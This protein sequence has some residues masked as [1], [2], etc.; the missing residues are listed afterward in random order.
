MFE[1][2]LVESTGKLA[3]RS[4]WTL[5]FSLAVQ[6]LIAGVLVLLPLIYM[7]ALPEQHL[8]RVLEAPAPP[9]AAA[10]ASPRVSRSAAP[11]S[12]LDHGVLRPPAEIPRMI[13]I[14]QDE[15]PP[16][17]DEASVP[18]GVP[19]GVPNGVPNS[20]ITQLIPN[21]P[22]AL[23]TVVVQKVRVSSGVAQGLLVHEVKP[24][25]P[26]LARQARIQGTVVLQ[27]VIGK[28]GTV[29]NLHVVSGHPMLTQAAIE[30]VKQW[31]Y[32]PYY[33]NGEPIEVDTQI[34]VNFTLA[35]G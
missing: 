3:R 10:P 27:A 9:P 17:P 7:E 14:V 2:S 12:E 32:K 26:T 29:Q 20:L 34:S 11:V 31:R 21:P 33:L 22:A 23:P 15:E 19:G 6:M 18:G 25:Y 35:G 24:Q 1:D 8:L 5:A 16:R 4:P 28:D 30:A 13:A